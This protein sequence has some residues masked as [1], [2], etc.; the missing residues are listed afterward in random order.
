MENSRKHLKEASLL[1][2]IFAALSFIRLIVQVFTGFGP[3]VTGEFS[4]ELVLATMIVVFAINFILLLPQIY[5]GIRGLKNAKSPE[6]SKGHIVW[7]VILLAFAIF[8]VF[9]PISN[10]MAKVDVLDNVIVLV[11]HALDI[12]VYCMFIKYAAGVAKNV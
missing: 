8:S 12:I 9:S 6:S 4:R 2:L 11:D 7:A 3:T 10:L 1:V 5:V